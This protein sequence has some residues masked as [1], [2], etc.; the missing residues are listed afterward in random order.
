VFVLG[1]CAILISKNLMIFPARLYDHN[2]KECAECALGPNVEMRAQGDDGP[3]FPIK[4][5]VVTEADVKQ[6]LGLE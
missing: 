6:I 4:N 5:K 3:F 2:L 1:R